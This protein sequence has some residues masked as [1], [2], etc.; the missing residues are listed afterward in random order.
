MDRFGAGGQTPQPST[1]ANP[2][3]DGLGIL[4]AAVTVRELWRPAVAMADAL[5]AR[6][7]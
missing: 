6:F 1:D 7:N 4:V 3:L 2:E 5:I